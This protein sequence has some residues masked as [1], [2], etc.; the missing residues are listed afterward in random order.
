MTKLFLLLIISLIIKCEGSDIVDDYYVDDPGNENKDLT[1]VAA[2]ID[3][4]VAQNLDYTRLSVV[5]QNNFKNCGG[6]L[7]KGLYVLTSASCVYE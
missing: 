5:F 4:V 7:V 2:G 6:S 1:R 3:S